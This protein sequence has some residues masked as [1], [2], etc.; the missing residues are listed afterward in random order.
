M[1]PT[2]YMALFVI[3]DGGAS[4]PLSIVATQCPQDLRHWTRYFYEIHLPVL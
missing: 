4:L 2:V 1:F 3:F